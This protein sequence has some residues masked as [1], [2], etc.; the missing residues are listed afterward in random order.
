MP[1]LAP[2]HPEGEVLTG[3]IVPQ[4]S[5]LTPQQLEAKLRQAIPSLAAKAKFSE[6]LDEKGATL[7]RAAEVITNLMQYSVDERVQIETT[8]MVLTAHGALNDKETHGAPVFNFV[9]AG[10]EVDINAILQ[11][12]RS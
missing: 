6:L 11:P 9:I 3:E 5:A 12:T 2:F 1:K 8:R 10:G 4:K 7:E